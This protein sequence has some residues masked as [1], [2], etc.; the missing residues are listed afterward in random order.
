MHHWAEIASKAL[1]AVAALLLAGMSVLVIWQVVTRYF[2]G[3]APLFAE[4]LARYAM[5]WM[6]LFAAAA[7]V[8][9]NS[10]IRIDFVPDLLR[11]HAPRA[12]RWLAMVLAAIS[13]VIFAAIAWYGL[14]AMRFAAGQ[15]SD[16]LRISL[17]WPYAVLPIAFVLAAVLAV[18]R[19]IGLGRNQ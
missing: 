9:D 1:R 5:I 8:T 15:R 3:G 10:H 7:S 6:A 12:G 4:E 14:D 13:C 16:G 18:I 17:A 11:R 2:L 19:L